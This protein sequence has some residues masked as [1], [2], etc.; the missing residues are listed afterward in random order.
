MDTTGEPPAKL[1]GLTHRGR[2]S[3]AAQTQ[4]EQR[5]ELYFLGSVAFALLV[6][7][8]GTASCSV[9]PASDGNDRTKE[10]EQAAEQARQFLEVGQVLKERPIG[11]ECDRY[12]QLVGLGPAGQ[13][14]PRHQE[15]TMD[16]SDLELRA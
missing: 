8:Y 2:R 15:L 13:R 7:S 1:R 6:Q 16:D 14:C 10:T 12:V 3:S 11:S 9:D 5:N 4:R